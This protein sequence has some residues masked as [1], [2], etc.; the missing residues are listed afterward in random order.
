MTGLEI[1]IHPTTS[2]IRCCIC[3]LIA[4]YMNYQILHLWPHRSLHQL[5][6]I[7]FVT[8][9]LTISTIRY[10]ICDLVGY[11]ISYQILHLLPHSSRYQLSDIA[12]LTLDR[13]AHYVNYCMYDLIAHFHVSQ[14]DLGKLVLTVFTLCQVWTINRTN[15]HTTSCN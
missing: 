15:L 7:A 5:S 2:A 6:D 12:S 8:S 14:W 3:D 10:C 9:K 13:I 11:Y 4:H 1:S